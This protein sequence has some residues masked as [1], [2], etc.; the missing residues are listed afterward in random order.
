[1]VASESCLAIIQ[2]SVVLCIVDAVSAAP[3]ET[4]LIFELGV[5]KSDR[6]A[7]MR[8]IDEG[9]VVLKGSHARAHLVESMNATS[10]IARQR[11][12]DD[13]S[14][15][16]VDGQ[17]VFQRNTLFTSPSAA[18]TAVTGR[19]TNGWTSWKSPHGT[20]AEVYRVEG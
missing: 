4:E 8:R 12:L 18:G 16:E 11:L 17:L 20:L 19:S 15:A 3:G 5:P 1:M 10:R 9:Y 2:H 6:L 7:R 14:L 13:G